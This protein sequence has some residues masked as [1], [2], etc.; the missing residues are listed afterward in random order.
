MPPNFMLPNFP[1][2]QHVPLN[3]PF[4]PGF[5]LQPRLPV[6]PPPGILSSTDAHHKNPSEN[7]QTD[8][9][10]TPAH[11][12]TTPTNATDSSA[13]LNQKPSALSS[14]LEFESQGPSNNPY[15]F[16]FV[17]PG[18]GVPFSPQTAA[19]MT[20][21]FRPQF[22]VPPVEIN[23]ESATKAKPKK[24]KK[25]AAVA[26][27]Q[28]DVVAQN[29]L[30]EPLP[31]KK[32]PRKTN[33]RGKGKAKKGETD[34]ENDLDEDNKPAKKP[35]KKKSKKDMKDSSTTD[36][37]DESKVTN[38]TLNPNASQSLLA[39][40]GFMNNPS[41]SL[42]QSS[43]ANNTSTAPNAQQQAQIAAM[44]NMT[45]NFAAY[46]AF[47]NA[48][49]PAFP[50]G[51][52]PPPYG[53]HPAFGGG[54]PP[55]GQPF[56]FRPPTMTSNAP[57]STDDKSATPIVVPETRPTK[58]KSKAKTNATGE[59]KKPAAP[60]GSKKKAA[61]AASAPS[62]E[63]TENEESTMVPSTETTGKAPGTSETTSTP[64]P[65]KRRVS[66][67]ES[68]D[69]DEQNDDQAQT[70]QAVNS[71]S[72][73]ESDGSIGNANQSTSTAPEKKGGRTTIKPQ[74]LEVRLSH[75]LF[76]F[77]SIC[78]DFKQII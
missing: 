64:P 27:E 62:T 54:P 44:Y 69:F 67:T 17:T 18:P 11:T 72:G 35:K 70:S 36:D 8:P 60:R 23:Q 53:F 32:K 5:P 48:Y 41:A 73:N 43:S 76:S 15:P 24:G 77:S 37:N 7:E 10:T 78:L 63:T 29:I 55:P 4:P 16:P 61:A 38:G 75:F 31:P 49:N 65:T 21:F 74:Q 52:Y 9:S 6:P 47:P 42:L 40:V 22:N 56:P 28:T 25:R 12:E 66:G 68:E 50:P 1:T 51:P 3:H 20:T 46:N 59:K 30:D 26:A 71:K 13:N 19:G 2:T 58:S 34:G 39:Q 14:L 57:P 45:P 33:P